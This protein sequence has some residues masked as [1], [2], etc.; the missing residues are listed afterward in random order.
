MVCFEG[1]AALKARGGGAR[2]NQSFIADNY[3]PQV[4]AVD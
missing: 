1:G 3:I 4:N 2:S